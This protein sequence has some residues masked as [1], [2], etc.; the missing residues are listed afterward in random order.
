MPTRAAGL[1]VKVLGQVQHRMHVLPFLAVMNA[2]GT[3]SRLGK[4]FRK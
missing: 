4:T 2:I 3:K 1:L